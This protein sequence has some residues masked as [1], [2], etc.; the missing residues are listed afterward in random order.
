MQSI[1]E[2]TEGEVI[3]QMSA[4]FERLA[5]LLGWTGIWNRHMQGKRSDLLPQEAN[6]MGSAANI[7]ERGDLCDF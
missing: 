4:Q 6:L 7:P 5:S 3:H 1:N 2:T